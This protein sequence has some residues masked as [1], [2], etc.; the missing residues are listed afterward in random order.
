[1]APR[2]RPGGR[3]WP[4]AAPTFRAMRR[5]LRERLVAGAQRPGIRGGSHREDAQADRRQLS[6]ASRA[7]PVV[8]GRPGAVGHDHDREGQRGRRCGSASSGPPAPSGSDRS[9]GSRAARHAIAHGRFPTMNAASRIAAPRAP[10]TAVGR[11]SSATATAIS[12]SGSS[13]P[14]TRA[15]RSGTPK[16]AT[17]RREP[18]RSRS[19]PMPAVR[20]TP[21]STNRSAN[22]AV[23][24]AI[25]ISRAGSTRQSCEAR[26]DH[27]R[28]APIFTNQGHAGVLRQDRA[29]PDPVRGLRARAEVLH[30]LAGAAGAGP[31]DA[32]AGLAAAS[33]FLEADPGGPA[34]GGQRHL[35]D[36]LRRAHVDGEFGPSASTTRRAGSTP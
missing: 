33:A 18:G 7:D 6:R 24:I 13:T 5:S 31:A 35:L 25:R 22:T 29:A 26:L 2:S 34:R 15:A 28:A 21:A 23:A 3:S 16:S 17:A 1:M 4:P 12:A 10:Q 11:N 32:A 27:R 19:F 9:N 20:K 14:T 36:L 8:E 30:E